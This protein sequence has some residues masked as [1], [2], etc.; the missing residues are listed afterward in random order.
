MTSKDAC[1]LRKLLAEFL[2][3]DFN[4]INALAKRDNSSAEDPGPRK[5]QKSGAMFG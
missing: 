4:F 1:L 5:G 3:T 2:D